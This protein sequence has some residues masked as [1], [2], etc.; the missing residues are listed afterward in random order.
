MTD[1]TEKQTGVKGHQKGKKESIL[2]Y[3][4]RLIWLEDP[5]TPL[6]QIAEK[7]EVTTDTVSQWKSGYDWEATYIDY[8]KRFFDSNLE[9]RAVQYSN[10]LKENYKQ[11][12]KLLDGKFGLYECACQNLGLMEGEPKFELTKTEALQIL[13]KTSITD[14]HKMIIRNLEVPY[15]LNDKQDVTVKQVDDKKVDDD[16]VIK[17]IE[18]LQRALK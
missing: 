1:W 16:S 9:E 2:A 11:T 4:A 7:L 18:G 5:N 6:Y 3:Q 17:M 10:F 13:N 12:K 15:T 14:L 8:R